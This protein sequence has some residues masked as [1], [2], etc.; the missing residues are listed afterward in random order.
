MIHEFLTSHASLSPAHEKELMEKRGFTKEIIKDRRFF[1][2]GKYLLA[3]EQE[4]LKNFSE[5]NL[6]ASGVFIKPDRSDRIVMSPHLQSDRVIIPYLNIDNKA[7]LV[8]PHKLG[9]EVPI[10]VYHEKVFLNDSKM[11]ILTESEFKAVAG[12]AYGYKTIGIPGVGSFSDLHFNRFMQFIQKAGVKQIC[13]IYDNEVKGDPGFPNYKEDPFKRYDTEYFAYYM[14]IALLREGVDARIGTLPDTWRVNGKVD[15]D[16]AL[17]QGRSKEDI[18]RVVTES[19]NPRAYI[20]DLSKEA[21]GILN[22]KLAKKYH[23]T[24]ISVDWGK[25]VANR[26]AGKTE[27]PEIISN[28]TVKIIA[29]HETAEGVVREVVLADEF[30]KQSHSFALPSEPM[31]K[32][33]AFSNFVMNKGNYVWK[34]TTDDLIQIWSGLFLEDDGRYI[35]EPDHVGWVPE[36]RSWVFGNILVKENGEEVR[37]D[38]NNIFWVEKHGIKPVPISVTSGKTAISE[39]IPIVATTE[40]D[41]NDVRQRFVES[42][43]KYEA[44]TLLGWIT[45]V[46]FMEEIFEAYNCFPFMFITGRRGSGKSTVAEWAMSFFG[47]EGGGR[48]A[49]DTTSVAMQRYLGYYSSLPVFI[50]EYRNTKQITMKNGFFRNVYNRQ[51]AGKGI[52][53]SFG[54]R[55]GKIRGTLLLAGE[56]TPEDNALLTRCIILTVLDKKRS[57][58]HF[59]WFQAHRTSLGYHTC[60]LLRQKSALKATFMENLNEGKNFFVKKGL[61]DRMALNY[62]VLGAGY[63]AAFGE[64]PKDFQEH[65]TEESR[66]TQIEYNQENAVNIFLDDLLM[67]QSTGLLR[68][69]MWACTEDRI[70]L[71]FAGLYSTWATEYRKIHGTEPFKATSIKH[72]LEE[73]PGFIEFDKVKR[74]GKYLRRCVVFLKDE[75]PNS[76]KTLIEES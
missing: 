22:R 42:I 33:E 37:P 53:A 8:R 45:A 24:N 68:E 35:V 3:L 44:Y 40:H 62:A 58:N 9:L 52:K 43:G 19:K 54:V 66:K 38:K 7:V 2:G 57:T 27:W 26:K 15:L 73:E 31:I 23:K 76:I 50:D 1:S 36:E 74:I 11:A 39:G 6:V 34:G 10:Q 60:R 56:E 41:M 51:S 32:R 59:N 46:L 72:Y 55:E 29:R 4:L 64:L 18:K 69:P 17:A 63:H 49:S 65:L 61:D 20:Q 12:E 5:E 70:F 47:I 28:F 14:A 75:A 30:G 67:F 48:Q 13:I 71:Y 16:G 21:Q 25:Y